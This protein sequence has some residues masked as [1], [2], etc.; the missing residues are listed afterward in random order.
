MKQ[1]LIRSNKQLFL[2][3]AI[4]SNRLSKSLITLSE[5]DSID[6]LRYQSIHHPL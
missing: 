1:V 4:I 3:L 5:A 6:L 2:C